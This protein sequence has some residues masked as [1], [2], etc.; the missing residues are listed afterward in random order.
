MGHVAHTRI[1]D[2]SWITSRCDIQTK[3]LCYGHKFQS[4]QHIS[5]NCIIVMRSLSDGNGETGHRMKQ[6]TLIF[7]CQVENDETT[8]KTQVRAKEISILLFHKIKNPK[9]ICYKQ[10][11]RKI[12]FFWSDAGPSF[13]TRLGQR[14]THQILSLGWA[15]GEQSYRQKPKGCVFQ[16]RIVNDGKH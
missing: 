8:K 4:H 16:D 13:C 2:R 5:D 9:N 1:S 6:V 10:M 12:Y 7:K 11:N 3:S 14:I 15:Q